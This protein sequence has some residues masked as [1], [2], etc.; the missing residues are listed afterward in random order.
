MFDEFFA[1]AH[2]LSQKGD[3]FAT[4]MV[5]RAERPTSGKPGDKAIV[6]RDGV[7]YGWIGGSCAQP[8]VIREAL[9]ALEDHRSRLIRIT[10]DPG[11]EPS[12]EGIQEIPMT[13]FSGGTI[14][15][16]IE[17]QDPQPR[18]LVVGHLPVAKALVHLGRAMSYHTIAV[19]PETGGAGLEDADQ[20]L[21]D[22][23]DLADWIHELTYVVVATHGH[24][25]EPALE[26]ALAAGARYVGLISS[27]KRAK[28]I[29]EHLRREGFGDEELAT[30][31]AP[32]G[33]DLGSRRGDEIALSILAEIVQLRR[34][35]EKAAAEASESTPAETEEAGGP[36]TATD[37]ICGMSVQIEGAHHTYEH[38]GTV[39]Y[40][41]C[42]GCRTKFME[43]PERHLAA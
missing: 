30:L 15:V 7:M 41:C 19:D 16:Y 37:P 20:V 43:D 27:P 8:A 13:C 17:P 32:A 40:F 28:P 4:A 38:E 10:P 5:V 3:P 33:L 36:E 42:G 29:V 31:H 39:Y 9:A 11:S 2:E 1:K 34:Q 26:R 22:L 25:D 23:D 35:A 21:T 24:Y 18:L 12:P 6:T 14:D